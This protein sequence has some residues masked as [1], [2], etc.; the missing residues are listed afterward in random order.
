MENGMTAMQD[1]ELRL[2]V[3]AGEINAIRT[4]AQQ[5]MISA[6]IEI[7]KRLVEAKSRV[8]HGHFREWLHAHTEYSERN[9]QQLMQLF[10]TYGKRPIEGV[11]RLT[12]S[13]AIALMTAP[14]EMRDELIG[15]GDADAM[16]V[17]ELRAEIDA[18]K[19]EIAEKQ[20]TIDQMLME[21][22]QQRA[23]LDTASQQARDAVERANRADQAKTKAAEAKRRAEAERDALKGSVEDLRNQLDA[24]IARK[25]EPIIQQ[26][27]V[28]PDAV[29]EELERLRDQ[30]RRAP[31]EATIQVRSA[32]ER[33]L[34]EFNGIA[35][36]IPRMAEAE[37]AKYRK[38]FACGLRRMAEQFEGEESGAED[39]RPQ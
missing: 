25:S 19:Q 38:A 17:R 27:E 34:A 1:N 31:D 7:G 24:E 29:S 10:E 39:D 3:L 15:S 16:S 30:L 37:Q 9:A 36:I 35:E 20:V 14:E 33:I 21:N 26:V 2:T 28:V 13:K 12:V 4:Q 8:A 6:A 23:A 32:Y 5:T 11:D 18:R 22:Q